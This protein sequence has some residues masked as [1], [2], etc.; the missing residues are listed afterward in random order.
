MIHACVHSR[1]D[2]RR[3]HRFANL[4]VDDKVTATMT[5]MTMIAFMLMMLVGTVI[6]FRYHM[7]RKQSSG[8]VYVFATLEV[9]IRH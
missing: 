6:G 2:I 8:G 9:S 3:G 4:Y 5:M 7:G 1:A